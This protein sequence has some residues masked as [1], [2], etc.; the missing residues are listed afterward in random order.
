VWISQAIF[1]RQNRISGRTCRVCS[2]NRALAK[3]EHC[4]MTGQ[5]EGVRASYVN[6]SASSISAYD[7]DDQ[8][9]AV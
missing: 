3:L 6:G 5:R 4:Y 8:R 2:G 9:G 7:D 1:V